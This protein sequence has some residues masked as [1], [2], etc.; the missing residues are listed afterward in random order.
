M[1]KKHAISKKRSLFTHKHQ[2]EKVD[3]VSI[4]RTDHI[5]Y[6]Y[7]SSRVCKEKKF[8]SIV[9]THACIFLRKGEKPKEPI[10][11]LIQR[12][13]LICNLKSKAL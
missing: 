8:S 2:K 11:A 12:R 10:K 7:S 4:G 5:I 6:S 9:Y 1:H 13:K 3:D